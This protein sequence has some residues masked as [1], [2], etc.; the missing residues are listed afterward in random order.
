MAQRLCLSPNE[1]RVGP[2]LSAVE[3]WGNLVRGS[4]E[5]EHNNARAG[6]PARMVPRSRLEA[7]CGALRLL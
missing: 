7:L 2:A 1:N 4:V 6:Q 5:K 3:G